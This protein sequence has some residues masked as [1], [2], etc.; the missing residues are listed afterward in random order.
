MLS[1]FLVVAY[2]IGAG[3]LVGLISAFKM[4][5]AMLVPLA[6]VWFPEAMSDYTVGHI[7]RSSPP[8]FVWFFGWM[9]LLLPI[10]VGT[11]LWLQQVRLDDL[12]H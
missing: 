7:T 10:I 2:V 6:C 12:L 4:L 8:S 11:L 5:A 1:V 3:W 9:I